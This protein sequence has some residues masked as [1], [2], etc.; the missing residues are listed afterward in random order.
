MLI[1]LCTPIHFVQMLAIWFINRR[2]VT[3]NASVKL[4]GHAFH[5]M[6]GQ[7]TCLPSA[8][9]QDVINVW[10]YRLCFS[11]RDNTRSTVICQLTR[12]SVFYLNAGPIYQGYPYNA[13]VQAA[14]ELMVE[15][16]VHL[17]QF[18]FTA[19]VYMR[20]HLFSNA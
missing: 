12:I 10:M 1:L 2:S 14:S 4:K 6:L 8:C 20:L 13:A 11:L 9:Q 7:E 18:I 5:H 15:R 19:Y 17:W 3:M 16:A